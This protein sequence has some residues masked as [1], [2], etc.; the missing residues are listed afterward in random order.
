VCV[1]VWEGE[2]ATHRREVERV[3]ESVRGRKRKKE[4]GIQKETKRGNR[5][6]VRL[7]LTMR[8]EREKVW[9]RGYIIGE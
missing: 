9:E 3:C 8:R 4:R 5:E 7:R 2:V 6:R 1:R